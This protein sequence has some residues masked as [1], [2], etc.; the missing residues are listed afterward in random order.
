MYQNKTITRLSSDRLYRVRGM[1]TNVKNV[2]NVNETLSEKLKIECEKYYSV[3]YDTGWHIGREL[4]IKQN[5]CKIKF[6]MLIQNPKKDDIQ[7]VDKRFIIPIT[8]NGI[9][10]FTINK[11]VRAKIQKKF[12]KFKNN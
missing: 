10:S 4:H 8:L 6:C 9:N 1:N 7:E 2:T 11:K 12:K 3:Y 5:I